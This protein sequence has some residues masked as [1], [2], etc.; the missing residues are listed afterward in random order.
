MP[1]TDNKKGQEMRKRTLSREIA[2]KILYASDIAKE[3]LEESSRRF[4]RNSDILDEDVKEF[5]DYIVLGVLEK[6]DDIDKI[7]IKHAANWELSRMATIDR[8][9]LRISTFELLYAFE[10]PPKVAINE[11]IELAKKYGDKDSG[12]FVNGIL[13]NINKTEKKQKKDD[14]SEEKQ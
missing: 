14:V 4:W 12:K 3:S 8:N 7:I 9:I 13:D 6:N 11:A 5:S 2:L 10:I 1:H